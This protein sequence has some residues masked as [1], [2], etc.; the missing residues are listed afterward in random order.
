MRKGVSGIFLV[1]AAGLACERGALQP[2]GPDAGG[3]ESG[4]AGTGGGAGGTAGS[5]GG[6][7]GPPPPGAGCPSIATGV[8]QFNPCGRTYSLA[9]SPDGAFVAAGMEGRRPNAHL[10][11]LSDGALVRDFDG[12]G[13]ATYDV[14]FSPDAKLLATAGGYLDSGA[15]SRQP[16]VVKVWNVADGSLVRTIPAQCGYS[17]RWR[18]SRTTG[19]C[20]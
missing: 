5:L 9:Y 16:E 13:G 6:A 11:R 2:G 7:G 20:W 1:L 8:R 10:W 3:G 4:A 17:P 15:L 14:A 12:V 18:R 19:P